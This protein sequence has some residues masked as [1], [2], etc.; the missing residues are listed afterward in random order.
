M[1]APYDPVPV[2]NVS[3][4]DIPSHAVVQPSDDITDGAIHVSQPTVDGCRYVL[5]N[6]PGV[7]PA[8][9]QGQ[10]YAH[11]RVV[12]A[13]ESQ[14]VFGN[15]WG[16]KAGSWELSPDTP[17]GFLSLGGFAAGRANWLRYGAPTPGPAE[18]RRPLAALRVTECVQLVSDG[19]DDVPAFDIYATWSSAAGDHGGWVGEETIET[20]D[21]TTTVTLMRGK[22][23]YFLEFDGE[24]ETWWGEL[25]DCDDGD[26]IFAADSD[27][28]ADGDDEGSG[29]SAFT[30]CEDHSFLTRVRCAP[31]ADECTGY[32]CCPATGAVIYARTCDDLAALYCA[33]DADLDGL[34]P[35]DPNI[36]TCASAPARVRM[37]LSS[38]IG[39]IGSRTCEADRTEPSPGTYK[40]T[41]VFPGMNVSEYCSA[42]GAGA[43]ELNC[44]PAWTFTID[45]GGW[46]LI[47]ASVSPFMMTYRRV[48]TIPE[49]GDGVTPNVTV[50]GTSTVTIT[51]AP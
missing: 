46:T 8:G 28:T 19:N 33:D 4:E 51:E 50:S 16:A 1:P 3:G 48:G 9:K 45:A 7:I 39:C 29:A 36:P 38:T 21:G 35:D 43:C 31:C 24:T 11:P 40:W 30:A 49:C 12:V 26:R 32:Y 23:Y 5:V 22:G 15:E 37:D 6:G 25:I 42:D 10:A 14:P 13:A 44:T 41:G 27:P 2:L 18:C 20:G 34:D 47:A 17:G